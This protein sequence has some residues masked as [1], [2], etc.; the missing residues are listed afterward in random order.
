MKN[1]PPRPENWGLTTPRQSIEPI[2]AS[3]AFPPAR[4]MFLEV[5]FK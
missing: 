3:T 4:S 2:A 1:P 5:R